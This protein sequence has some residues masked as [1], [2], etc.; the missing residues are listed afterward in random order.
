MLHLTTL[1]SI[2]PCAKK[3]PLTDLGGWWN[4]RFKMVN[5]N[6]NLLIIIITTLVS[7]LA[8]HFAGCNMWDL[9]VNPYHLYCLSFRHA[10]LEVVKGDACD[11]ESFASVLKG[12]DAVMSCLG[13]VASIFNPTTFYSE[14]M[15]AIM[16][17]MRRCVKNIEPYIQA[18]IVIMIII[19]IFLIVNTI[20]SSFSPVITVKPG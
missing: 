1:W 17:G 19:F 4:T 6:N 2:I 3:V 7:W 14:S 10:N 5:I 18:S 12:K 13:V 9:Y 20:G 11:V 16:E 8:S 15:H